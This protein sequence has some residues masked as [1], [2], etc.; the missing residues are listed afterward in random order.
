M[1]TSHSDRQTVPVSV[2]MLHYCRPSLIMR[3]IESLLMQTV[4]PKELIILDDFSP[5]DD[6]WL[7]KLRVKR[8]LPYQIHTVICR[9]TYNQGCG[10][11]SKT[12]I[13]MS[14]QPYIAYL[15]SD[16][17]W[18]PTKLE[19]Q[20]L[21][22]VDGSGYLEKGLC[23]TGIQHEST[24]LFGSRRWEK[25]FEDAYLGKI[26]FTPR[27]SLMIRRNTLA[28]A[29]GHSPMRQA[30]DYATALRVM[31]ISRT[32]CIDEPMLIVPKNDERDRVSLTAPLNA[33][34]RIFWGMRA[35]REASVL[36]GRLGLRL[37]CSP[38][39]KAL[40]DLKNLAIDMS[41]RGYK[42]CQRKLSR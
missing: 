11:A 39:L 32:Y 8:R 38:E 22:Y 6:Y 21:S 23:F 28:L 26:P 13:E 16:D 5:Y 7:M 18:T 10:R 36:V 37:P 2:I 41:Y 35:R 27:S 1:S 17:L 19:K 34:N 31:A 14:S 12:A 4:W 15:D 20:Y 25:A 30:D 3:S 42:R 29:G 40:K 33:V 24:Q 9:N